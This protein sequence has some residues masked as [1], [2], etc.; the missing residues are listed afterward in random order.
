MTPIRAGI[1]RSTP[2]RPVFDRHLPHSRLSHKYTHASA[3]Q[4]QRRRLFR[5]YPTRGELTF[6][7]AP[8]RHRTSTR[9]TSASHPGIYNVESV[10][11][12]WCGNRTGEFPAGDAFCFVSFHYP[13]PSESSERKV[14]VSTASYL[15]AGALLA[16]LLLVSSF[17]IP[18]A[19]SY[20]GYQAFLIT[21]QSWGAPDTWDVGA[22]PIVLSWLANVGALFGLASLLIPGAQKPWVRWISL[23]GLLTLGPLFVAAEELLLGYYLWMGSIV[24]ITVLAFLRPRLMASP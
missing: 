17:F 24:A 5:T 4:S 12:S 3:A 13:L 16:A 8:H 1:G 10:L 23:L 6:L 14:L 21:V 20:S 9:A 2:I 15:R 7:A 19:E 11:N 18:V 22:L